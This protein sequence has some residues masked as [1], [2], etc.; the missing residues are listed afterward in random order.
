MEW[1][2]CILPVFLGSVLTAPMTFVG[3]TTAHAR[4]GTTTVV[5]R[6]VISGRTERALLMDMRRKGPRVQG[7][8]ALASTK[9]AAH[10]AAR[11]ERRAGTCRVRDFRLEA[12]FTMQLPRL[13]RQRGL[14]RGTRKR[15]PAFLARLRRHENR[16]ISIWRGCLKQADRELQRL[17]ARSCLSLKRKMKERY[18]QIMKACD[19]KHDAF[20][21]H[22]HHVARNLP[23][24][25]AAIREMRRGYRLPRMRRTRR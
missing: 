6:Y 2:R 14:A 11:L 8:P 18:R 4:L 19:R 7:H 25:R 10:Y 23:F 9:L 1:K 3:A 15:W 5:K 20:D 21:A 12:T 13:K 16:H 17:S 24:I 22:E